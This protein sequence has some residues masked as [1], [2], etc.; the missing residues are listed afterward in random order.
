MCSKDLSVLGKMLG[1]SLLVSLGARLSR[2]TAGEK[3]GKHL[4][5]LQSGTHPTIQDPGLRF[6]PPWA[7][8]SHAFGVF[9]DV[10]S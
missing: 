7:E 6:V 4:P 1:A 5:L 2:P 3:P 10:S 8:V 9:Q